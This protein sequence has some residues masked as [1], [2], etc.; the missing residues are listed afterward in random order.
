M[1]IIAPGFIFGFD[2]DTETVFRDTLDFLIEVGMIGGDPSFL[3]ALSGTPLYR[4]M[5]QTG[6]LIERDDKVTVRAKIETN[7]R[8]L[9]DSEFLANGFIDFINEYNGAEFQYKRFKSH[10]DLIMNSDAYIP[11]EGVGY[12]SPLEYLKLQLRDPGNRKM[13]FL[14]IFYLLKKPSNTWTAIKA[15]LYLKKCSRR[16][17]GLD[18]HF[19]YWVYVWTNIG[20][21]YLTLKR[22]DIKIHSVGADFD[23]SLLAEGVSQLKKRTREERE[24]GHEN[25][26]AQAHYTEKALQRLISHKQQ[27]SKKAS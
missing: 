27:E 12:G 13:L 20:L 3:M 25:T 2:S 15:W 8:Y 1:R 17:K 18:V 5:Q 9:Q 22:E 19:H 10:L 24:Q 21:K 4:R 7:V 16:F 6:R 14:R 11:N 26:V 23:Y